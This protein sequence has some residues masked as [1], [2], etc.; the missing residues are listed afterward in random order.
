MRKKGTIPFGIVPLY[1][2]TSSGRNEVVYLE[3]DFF[4]VFVSSSVATGVATAWE[5]TSESCPG[6]SSLMSSW[7]FESRSSVQTFVSPV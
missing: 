7:V 1:F 4:E 3:E 5:I 2:T 6:I